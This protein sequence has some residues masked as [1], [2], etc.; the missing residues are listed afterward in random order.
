MVNIDGF[1]EIVNGPSNKYSTYQ[2][3]ALFEYPCDTEI[4]CSPT[5][6]ILQRGVYQFEAWGGQGGNATKYN[7]GVLASNPQEGGRGG[8]SIGTLFVTTTTTFFVY[9]GSKGYF[10]DQLNTSKG[11]VFGC[12]GGVTVPYNVDSGYGT[13]GGGA[14]DIRVGT[15]SL[16]T[17]IVVAAGGGGASGGRFE[18][19]RPGGSGGGPVGSNG[20]HDDIEH[21]EWRSTGANQDG[22]GNYSKGEGNSG[23]LGSFG[24]GGKAENIATGRNYGG[25]G[26]GGWYGGSGGGH[27]VPGAGGS[28]FVFN[29]TKHIPE[30]Y[31]LDLRYI[32]K[33]TATI[34]GNFSFP[35]PSLYYPIKN[36]TGHKGN[37]AVKITLVF[38]F[39]NKSCRW[40][41]FKF[42]FFIYMYNH[43][44]TMQKLIKYYSIIYKKY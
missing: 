29:D 34:N 10:L 25:G 6:I 30:E 42:F 9:V 41:S 26:G 43:F 17:R 4:E 19:M 40:Y 27:R 31:S 8:Y 32:L 15:D 28:G 16:Y 3:R 18:L 22:P 13:S 44:I 7:N 38:V 21:P 24:C 14:S 37:G 35:T 39:D 2:N 12:G 33:D 23:N 1:I 11:D 20:Y 5:E 36:E